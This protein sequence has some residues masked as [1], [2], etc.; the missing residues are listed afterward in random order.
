[1]TNWMD[2]GELQCVTFIV[3]SAYG[4]KQEINI[5]VARHDLL[6]GDPRKPGSVI[7][8][9]DLDREALAHVLEAAAASLRGASRARDAGQ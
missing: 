7:A 8:D 1:V 9:A 6:H 5:T 2:L 4:P 3:A